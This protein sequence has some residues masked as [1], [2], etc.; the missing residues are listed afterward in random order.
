MRESTP[1][2]F[3][4]TA[5]WLEEHR[6]HLTLTRSETQRRPDFTRTRSPEDPDVTIVTCPCGA[7]HYTD[8]PEER[9][10]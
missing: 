2:R 1:D 5:W 8:A 4:S 7:Q 6:P 9:P 3:R 10:T